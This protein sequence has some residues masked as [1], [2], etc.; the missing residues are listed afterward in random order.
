MNRADLELMGERERQKQSAFRCRLLCC[1]STPCLSSG[2][3]AVQ[4][5]LL[6]AVAEQGLDAEVQVVATGCMGPCSRGPVV[7][8]Q[9]SEEE[10]TVYENVTPEVAKS[11]VTRH[12]MQD[13]PVQEHRAAPVE[14]MRSE[15]SPTSEHRIKPKDD[16]WDYGH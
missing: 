13:E 2:G 16:A 3:T 10:S 9:A 15:E 4:E 7:T 1:A 12:V 8:V 5:A 6:T 11:I 14:E